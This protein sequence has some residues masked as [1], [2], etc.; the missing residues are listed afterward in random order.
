MS[1]LI[2]SLLGMRTANAELRLV[3]RGPESYLYYT[4]IHR[5]DARPV[6]VAIVG[7][8]KRELHQEPGNRR[9]GTGQLDGETG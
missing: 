3:P 8:V 5:P 9:C 4:G 1:C 6:L 2:W 7:Q